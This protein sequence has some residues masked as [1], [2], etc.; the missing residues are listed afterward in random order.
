MHIYLHLHLTYMYYNVYSEHLCTKVTAGVSTN[1]YPSCPSSPSL[2]P[3]FCQDEPTTGMDP[4]TRRYLW[5]VLISVTKEGRSIVLTS[6][7]YLLCGKLH[8]LST[9]I[10]YMHTVHAYM[11]ACML[12]TC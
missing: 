8:S 5:D 4:A 10:Q 6:H 3:F 11:H 12:H 1:N 9:Y 7:R 2:P